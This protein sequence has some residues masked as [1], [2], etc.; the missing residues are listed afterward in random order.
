MP[1]S[2]Y[3]QLAK[4][5]RQ[6]VTQNHLPQALQQLRVAVK[7]LPQ[8][9]A[10]IMQ[11]N[12]YERLKNR[13]MMETH[14]EE[15]LDI[16]TNRIIQNLL[17]LAGQLELM[18]KSQIQVFISCSQ[19]GVGHGLAKALHDKVEES[20]FVAFLDTEDIQPGEDWATF[21]LAS[22]K[23]S[24]YFVLLLSPEANNSE[25][26]EREVM[27]A[28]KL[29][30]QY[31]KPVILPVRM[32]WPEGL[33]L[34]H[35]LA[36]WLQRIQHI[37]WEGVQDTN[38]VMGRLLDVIHERS[39]LRL[40]GEVQ[41]EEVEAFIEDLVHPP[42]PAAPL[43][44]PQGS[45]KLTSPFYIARKGEE[46]FIQRI[47]DTKACLRIRG[48]R[49]YGKTSLLSRVVAYAKEQGYEVMSMD[50]QNLSEHTLQSTE[51]LIWEFCWKIAY[52]V[53]LEEEFED[54]WD[55]RI[56]KRPDRDRKQV[57]QTFIEK[58]LF[59]ERGIQLVVALDEADR[60]FPYKQVSDEFFLMLRSW[61]EKS[62]SYP[63]WENFKLA[64]S[65]STE[66]KL[67]ITNLN[68]SPFNVGIEARLYPFDQKQIGQLL[69]LH[70]LSLSKAEVGKLEELLGGQPY[71]IR[72]AL[73]SLANQEYTFPTL[74]EAAATD[75]GPFSDHLRHHLIN[76]K[77]FPELAQAFKQIILNHKCKDPIH[78][79]KLAA[80]GLTIGTPPES[81]HVACGLYQ[82]YFQNKL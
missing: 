37:G 41:A 8:L 3:L 57:A 16:E 55:K 12:R 5:I 17:D 65:Y 26:V 23:A 45:V 1:Q 75:Q 25:M 14:A 69:E 21:I 62:N 7:D 20:G 33:A 42:I 54:Y 43:E 4:D 11:Q 77:Q 49:Q 10:V 28:R 66:A 48:P 44:V 27:E 22:I 76:I 34:N 56:A 73:F 68:A 78:A 40:T 47:T 67:A 64:I 60:I 39:T 72:K 2:S 81:V 61:H 29:Q 6:L 38:R 59:K 79:G 30:S 58:F 46:T 13:M 31:G 80:A 53:D 35:K 9:H 15:M 50:F 36:G 71:L 18:G 52:Q 63:I 32:K 82:D 70:S 19:R 24:D 51:N 74:M